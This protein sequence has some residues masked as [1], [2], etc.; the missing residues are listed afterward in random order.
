[1]WPAIS[2]LSAPVSFTHDTMSPTDDRHSSLHNVTTWFLAIIQY[3]FSRR[4]P[5]WRADLRWH[6]RAGNLREKF[7]GRPHLQFNDG[8][9]VGNRGM[10][11]W[12][13]GNTM[14]LSVTI[15]YPID[16]F[17]MPEDAI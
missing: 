8:R 16:F 11:R 17:P 4:V 13:S 6:A 7:E 1:M 14:S 5:E 3:L 15:I 10:Q 12:C 2:V 9:T